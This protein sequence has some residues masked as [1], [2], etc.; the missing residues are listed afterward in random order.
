MWDWFFAHYMVFLMVFARVTGAMLFNPFLQRRSV[1][2]IVK[3]GFSFFCAILIT[4]AVELPGVDFANGLVFTASVVKEMLIGFF[5]GFLMQ[6]FVAAVLV[7]GELIDLQLGVGMAR[8]YDPQ[9]NT[10]MPISGSLFQLFLIVTFFAVNGH[11]TLMKIVFYTFEVLPPGPQL[12][13]AAAWE[14][15]GLLFSQILV[16]AL[17]LALPIIAIELVTEVGLGISMACG[18]AVEH[19]C[20]GFAAETFGGAVPDPLVL[21]GVFGFLIRCWIKCFKI[22]SPA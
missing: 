6:L 7:S 12:F 19:L 18:A 13:N 11:L 16:L 5:L 2:I 3:V 8:L 1:S 20:C 9:S 4:T 22:S 15:V 17:K 10:S 14:Y 21:P